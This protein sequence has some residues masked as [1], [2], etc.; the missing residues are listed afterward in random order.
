M[1]EIEDILLLISQS[2]LSIPIQATSHN[3]PSRRSCEWIPIHKKKQ[4]P[5]NVDR[6]AIIA[7]YLFLTV[8]HTIQRNTKVH[9]SDKA[10]EAFVAVKVTPNC[11]KATQQ[12]K[13][14]QMTLLTK[15]RID[16]YMSRKMSKS[17][18]K[19]KESQWNKLLALCYSFVSS[20][21]AL[22]HCD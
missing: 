11:W 1:L 4:L 22:C 2:F 17:N 19:I 20:V 3:T 21:S 10:W 7:M 15:E 8:Y 16:A 12:Q 6:H 5:W 13:D 9:Y 14:E 18:G